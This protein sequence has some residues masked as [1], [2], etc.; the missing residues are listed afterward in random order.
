MPEYL[1]PGV[2]IEE[3]SSGVRPIE[4]AS[5]STA[6][7][8]GLTAK[9]VP[10]RATFITSYAEF[11][12]KFGDLVAGSLL[13]Y[14]VQQFFGNGGKRCYIVRVLNALSAVAAGRDFPD[15]ETGGPARSVLRVRADGAG[16]WGNSVLVEVEDGTENPTT[17]FKLLVY[18]EDPIVPVEVFDNL[19][20]DPAADGYVET[21]VNGASDFIRVEDLGNRT[22]PGNATRTTTNPLADPVPFAGGGETVTLELPDGTVNTVNFAGNTARADVVT[23][24]A[25]AWGPLNVSAELNAANRLVVR[26]NAAGFDRYFILGGPATAAGRPLEGLAGF[27][28][29]SGEATPGILKSAAAATFDTT[30]G[31]NVLTLLVHG[32]QPA[33]TLPAINL[34]VGPAVPIDTLRGE[35]E[36]VLQASAA[37]GLVSVSREGNRLVLSTTNRGAGNT[38]LE[39]TGTANTQLQFR[40]LDR[41]GTVATGQGRSEPAFVQSGPGPFALANNSNFSILVNNGALGAPSPP[42]VV[43]FTAAAIPNLAAVSAQTVANTINAAAGGAVVATAVNGRVLL[44]QS[45]RGRAY[46]LQVVDGQGS[47]NVQLRF[48]G[49]VQ[50]GWH[51]GDLDSPYY[52]PGFNLDALGVNQPRE[53]QGGDD[54][55]PPSNFDFIGTPA[56]KTG[57]HALDDVVDVSIIAIPG[58]FS[59]QVIGDALGY[60]QNR[61]DCF[62]IADSP[63]KLTRD[64]PVTDPPHA[65]DFVRNQLPVKSSYGALYYPWLEIAD[66]IGPGR[67]PRR[68]VPPSGFV[69]GLYARIDNTRGVFKAPAGTEA[70]LIGALGLEYSVTDAEQD[71]LHP[72]GVNCIRRFPASGLVIWGARTL[73]TQSDPEYRYVPV[74]R[75]TIYLEVSIYRGTQYAVHEPN[76]E[77]LWESLEANITDF[78]MG[79]FRKGALAGATPDEAFQVKCDRDLNPDS[80]VNAGRV[81]MEVR[82]APLKPAEFVIIRIS[83]KSQRPEG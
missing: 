58:N 9:G 49:G 36:A 48:D 68:F 35:I 81:N 31:N 30:G 16:A 38:R 34:T 42:I 57:L 15:R 77:T 28:Q 78:M 59:A 18:H 73:A 83:Q 65:Q 12:R 21:A 39:A 61:K 32:N 52:R 24:L 23:A 82:F 74:R 37:R 72:F 2:Y 67:N 71:I 46:T 51:E 27:A 19:S 55:S 47:P 53:L 54:G 50:H 70:N 66:P 45:R 6:G 14:A 3:V 22:T 10:N 62:F 33:D 79:E 11:V 56:T 8:V 1:H 76:D 41:S 75:Y 64:D 20:M 29:G 63:G 4:G 13:P 5:T 60:C 17:E 40:N 43:S 80:E 26:H 25:T 69:A 7:F 44:R